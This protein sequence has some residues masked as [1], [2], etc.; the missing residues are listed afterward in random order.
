[1][2]RFRAKK[3]NIGEQFVSSV[4]P[5]PLNCMKLLD[6]Y[7]MS[8][9][10]PSSSSKKSDQLEI[11]TIQLSNR[12][13]RESDQSVPEMKNLFYSI[14]SR[15]VREA[16]NLSFLPGNWSPALIIESVQVDRKKWCSRDHR[17][18]NS[19]LFIFMLE[20]FANWKSSKFSLFWADIY[21]WNIN[22][23]V[24]KANEKCR[25]D[26]RAFVKWTHSINHLSHC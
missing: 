19:T 10:N 15:A 12:H 26:W 5:S 18:D 7:G 2:K 11:V 17:N 14:L 22:Y 24:N 25:R 20:N 21:N 4:K 1:M 3:I 16:F 23:S 6:V 9:I 13:S 8:S